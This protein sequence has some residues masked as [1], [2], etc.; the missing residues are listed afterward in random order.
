MSPDFPD[1]PGPADPSLYG[2]VRALTADGSADELAGRQAAL[3]MFKYSRRPPR[4]RFAF[5]VTTAAAAVVIVGG[6]AA[7]YAAVLPASVQHMAHRMLGPVGV[8]DAYHTSLS[9]SAPPGATS[10][11][12][13]TAKSASAAA[14]TGQAPATVSASPRAACPCQSRAPGTNTAPVLVLTPAHAQIPAGGGE[15]LHGRLAPGGRGEPGVRVRLLELAAGRGWQAAGS[16]VTDRHGDVMLTVSHLTH[17]A[18]F[19]L[20]AQGVQASPPVRITVIP[21]VSLHLAPGRSPGV[22][23]L[24]AT[25]PF[26]DTGDIVI[27]QELSGGGW[28]RVVEH[29]LGRDHTASFTVRLPKSGGLEYRVVVPPTRS[30]GSSV[31]GRVRVA[32]PP[33]PSGAKKGSDPLPRVVG[34]QPG[35]GG[36]AASPVPRPDPIGPIGPI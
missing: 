16:A 28:H 35:A 12:S 11:P 24:T 31:S 1:G 3:A 10:I 20:A 34:K 4:R 32:A 19:R 5:P 22:D 9:A 8:P 13:T 14:P 15:V 18:S 27:L 7:A 26:A 23:T 33:G 2:L 29:A 30:H 17:N 36:P 6:I 21:P 25:A